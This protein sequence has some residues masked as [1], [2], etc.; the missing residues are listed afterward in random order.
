MDEEKG[1]E[2]LAPAEMHRRRE[3][4]G[5]RGSLW[6]LS[7]RKDKVKRLGLFEDAHLN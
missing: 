7:A 4:W 5:P 1:P 2:T 3:V 6:K